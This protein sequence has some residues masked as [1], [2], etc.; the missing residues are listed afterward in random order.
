MSRQTHCTSTSEADIAFVN[1]K[2]A[3]QATPTLGLPDPIRPAT[4]TVNETNGCMKSLL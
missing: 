3:L 1:L 2:L 4:Q